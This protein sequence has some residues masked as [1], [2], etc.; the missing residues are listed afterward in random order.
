MVFSGI[1]EE[2]GTVEAMREVDAMTLWD[3]SVGSGW[4]LTVRAS[5]VNDAESCYIGASIAVNGTCLTVTRFVAGVD[6]DV[7]ISPETLRCTNLGALASGEKINLERSLPASARNSGHFVQGHVDATGTILRKWREG[8]S[9]WIRIALP[10]RLLAYV[11][12]KG[13]IAVDGT[14]L[15]V[16][17]VKNE[18]YTAKAGDDTDDSGPWFTVMLIQHTQ[19]CIIMPHKEDGAAVNLE[20]DVLSKYAERASLRL[21]SRLAEHERRLA[22]IEGSTPTGLSS[23]QSV[24]YGVAFAAGVLATALVLLRRREK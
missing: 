16:C 2:M 9:L 22:V 13:Y 20:V 3:G 1:V 24:G 19:Q 18:S 6:F 12:P 8:D 4:V 17:D 10:P 15:T 21:E 5:I 23:F 14:S 11:V 7:G